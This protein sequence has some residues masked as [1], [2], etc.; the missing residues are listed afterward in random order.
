VADEDASGLDLGT[1]LE[2]QKQ[3]KDGGRWGIGDEA[4]MNLE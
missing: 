2:L 4:H 3:G 1:E